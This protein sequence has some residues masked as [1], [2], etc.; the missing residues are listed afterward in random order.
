MTNSTGKTDDPINPAT[1][2]HLR[3]L[4][5]LSQQGL[6]KRVNCKKD[7]ISR[8]ER[9]LHLDVRGHK[10]REE[11]AQALHVKWPVLTEP[12]KSGL[13]EDKPKTLKVKVSRSL[14]NKLVLLESRYRLAGLRRSDII[15]LAPLLF[16]IA[17][18]GSLLKRSRKLPIVEN[19]I[20]EANEAMPH[21][22]L[23]REGL[24]EMLEAEKESIANNDITGVLGS[25]GI[26]DDPFFQHIR[27]LAEGIPESALS[28]LTYEPNL[29][30]FS[31][32]L[33]DETLR[34]KTRLTDSAADK[35]K[36]EM[37][38]AGSL[39]LDELEKRIERSGLL[40]F[41]PQTG[42]SEDNDKKYPGWLAQTI[43]DMVLE[44]EQT[45]EQ[46]TE[47]ATEEPNEETAEEHV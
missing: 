7:T 38:R 20:N 21:H 5:G 37:F 27:D 46:A 36:V 14:N 23:Q 43:D 16:L 10:V 33:A 8:W 22:E 4:R 12:I 42:S 35:K 40:S 31:Y 17:A 26:G 11:L 28:Q 3:K 45:E 41:A 1:L 19:A 13:T 25:G 29:G 39:D 18:E 2:K 32:E 24:D 6:A 47:P 15:E 44:F 9:G 30:E 34:W